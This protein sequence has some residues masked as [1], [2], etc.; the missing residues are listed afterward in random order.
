MT[1]PI[2]ITIA[3]LPTGR[4]AFQVGRMFF[5]KLDAAERYAA[6][7]AAKLARVAQRAAEAVQAVVKPAKAPRLV[8][9]RQLVR[10]AERLIVPA[11]ARAKQAYAAHKGLTYSQVVTRADRSRA[12]D[13][14]VRADRLHRDARNRATRLWRALEAAIASR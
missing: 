13:R 10:R 3:T 5:A 8:R 14:M 4:V 1:T 12:W 2:S 9:L 11:K 7:L 6:N